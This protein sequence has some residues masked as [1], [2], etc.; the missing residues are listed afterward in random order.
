MASLR[1]IWVFLFWQVITGYAIT[2]TTKYYQF[3]V[4]E[5]LRNIT[6]DGGFSRI[7]SPGELTYWQRKLNDALPSVMVL[8]GVHA[9]ELFTTEIC[10]DWINQLAVSPPLKAN[11]LI[12]PIVN[13]SG[14]ERVRA[15]LRSHLTGERKNHPDLC[16]RTN[17]NG[18]DLNRNWPHKPLTNNK[19]T[20][21]S[22]EYPGYRSLSEQET[23]FIKQLI[24]DFHPDIIIDVH[25]GAFALLT[26]YDYTTLEP[27]THNQ[28][29]RLANK[30]RFNMSR[31]M[32]F[33]RAAKMLY[34]AYGTLQDYAYDELAVKFPFTVEVYVNS[35]ID[36]SKSP[37]DCFSFFNPTKRSTMQ[38]YILE[39]QKMLY[40]ILSVRLEDF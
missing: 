5:R 34:V 25:A 24:T 8:C 20:H 9:R 39:W 37:V 31:E 29:L 12:I 16:L 38:E 13:P 7:S 23:Q 30:L 27:S 35:A 40:N 3:T 17:A 10:A 22:E 33:G 14:S 1:L 11:W 6:V 15:A 21:S 28:I 19:S 4:E 26:P 2:T 32:D 18:V 36:E